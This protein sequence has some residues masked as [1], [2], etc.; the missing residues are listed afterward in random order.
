MDALM[1][2]RNRLFALLV[3]NKHMK[4]GEEERRENP[5]LRAK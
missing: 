4:V 1:S 3:S 5:L 2:L